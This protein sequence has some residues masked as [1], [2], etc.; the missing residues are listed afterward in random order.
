MSSDNPDALHEAGHL[1]VAAVF[2]RV[3]FGATVNAGSRLAG[4]S[5]FSSPAATVFSNAIG[6]GAEDFAHVISTI[7]GREVTG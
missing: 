3:L 1:A 7:G 5:R 4:C 6:D 2:G